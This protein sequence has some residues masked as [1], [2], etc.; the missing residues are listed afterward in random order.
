M[1]IDLGFNS[2]SAGWWSDRLD[3]RTDLEKYYA[4]CRKLLNI[5]PTRY[6]PAERRPGLHFVAEVKDSSKATG[7]IPL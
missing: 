3:G 6:G 1:G 4:A 2:F 5:Y 7:L